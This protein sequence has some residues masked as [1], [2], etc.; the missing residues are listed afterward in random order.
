MVSSLPLPLQMVA[1][2]HW[3][4]GPAGPE[5]SSASCLQGEL[6][7]P[8]LSCQVAIS[9]SPSPSLCSPSKWHIVRN[10]LGICDLGQ[11]VAGVPICLRYI[12]G[13]RRKR[14]LS[15]LENS[16]RAN[17]PF[18]QRAIIREAQ[19]NSTR[20]PISSPSVLPQPQ[21]PTSPTP[22]QI[23]LP[24]CFPARYTSHL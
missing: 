8:P 10:V 6:T 18:P 12:T 24:Q 23:G 2:P 20:K 3:H 16:R 9:A 21:C 11:I 22:S 4:A 15:I 13:P 7:A 14:N 17:W 5:A 19:P 1:K